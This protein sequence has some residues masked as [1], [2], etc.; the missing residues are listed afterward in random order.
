MKAIVY[1]RYGGPE[2]LELRDVPRPT[3]GEGEVLLEVH[4]TSINASDWEFLTGSPAYIRAWGPRRPKVSSLG[5]D[6]AG[7]VAA[8]GPGAQRFAVG[9]AVFGDDLGRWGGLA[10]YACVPEDTLTRK[11]DDLSFVD[12]AAIPQAACVGL[13]ALSKRGRI[14]AGQRVLV[15]GAGGGSGTFTVQFA[16][17]FGAEV[18]GVDSG[19]KLAVMRAAGCDHVVDPRGLLANRRLLA[20][21]GVYFLVGGSMRRILR[22]GLL[23]PLVSL[24]AGGRSLRMLM[25]DANA[26]M[27]TILRM[28]ADGAIRPIIDRRFPLE[29]AAAALRY[30]GDGHTKGKVVVTVAAA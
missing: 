24:G 27:E 16:K 14:A 11:P 2:V 10:E 13:Q 15:V 3:P 4:A 19:E 25:V 9:D 18:T 28:V 5:S 17:A 21:G 29:E 30:L 26:D 22:A 6:I 23:G 12:A 7:T 20:P 8:L 1:E